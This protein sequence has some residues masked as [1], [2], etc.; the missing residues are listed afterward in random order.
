MRKL[1]VILVIV[2]FL[3][4]S[5]VSA[6]NVTFYTEPEGAQVYVD[7]QYLGESPASKRMTNGVWADSRVHVEAEGY[8]SSY[9][10]V[11]KEIKAANLALGLLIWWPALLWVHGPEPRQRIELAPLED[12]AGARD[13]PAPQREQPESAAPPATADDGE[14]ERRSITAIE[15]TLAEGETIRLGLVVRNADGDES[16]RLAGPSRNTLTGRLLERFGSNDSFQLVDR[17]ETEAILEEYEFQM[18]GLVD[19]SQLNEIGQLAGITHLLVVEYAREEQGSVLTVEDRRRLLD[20]RDGTALA[21]DTTVTTFIWD[22]NAVEYR[23]VSSTHN[24]RP[25]RIENGRL[26]RVE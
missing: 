18:S 16:G 2:S 8:K 23:E 12:G 21:A 15:R 11:D 14:I 17:D 19:E 5:C 26:Y 3:F 13:D 7:D 9:T 10:R 22:A 1:I 20:V 6:T 24:G 25:V 4:S